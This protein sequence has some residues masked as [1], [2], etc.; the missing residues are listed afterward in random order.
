LLGYIVSYNAIKTNPK[1]LQQLPN[2][3]FHEI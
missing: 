3:R 1:K 2:I